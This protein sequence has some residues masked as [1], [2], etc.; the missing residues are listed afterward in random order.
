MAMVVPDL[1]LVG[2]TRENF[3]KWSTMTRIYSYPLELCSRCTKSTEIKSKGDE[4]VIGCKGS[5]VGRC[6]DRILAPILVLGSLL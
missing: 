4:L 1:F 5:F 3:V 2:Y 6:H